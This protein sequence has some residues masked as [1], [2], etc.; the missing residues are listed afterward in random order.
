MNE[1][2]KKYL[3]I[4]ENSRFKSEFDEFYYSHPNY[5]SLFAVTDSLEALG[6]DNIAVNFPKERFL[7]L[8][9]TF[10]ANFQEGFVLVRKSNSDVRI[11]KENGEKLTMSNPSF[12][13]GWNGIILIIESKDIYDDTKR[14]FTSIYG[15]FVIL[16]LFLVASF[17]YFG[18]S[19][20]QVLG[21][22]VSLT[23]ISVSVLI[24]QEKF[25]VPN[26]VISKFCNGQDSSCNSVITSRERKITKN[27]SFS[28]VPFIFFSSCLLSL[29][30]DPKHSVVLIA[31]LSLSSIPVVIYSIWLQKAILR[32]W[33]PL[34]LIISLLMII[35]GLSLFGLEIIS[36]TEVLRDGYYYYFS[37]GAV[38][39]I[40]I[41]VSPQINSKIKSSERLNDLLRFKRDPNIFKILAKEIFS[42]EGMENLNG[43]HIGRDSCNL[44][45]KLFLSP[46]C[47]YCHSSYIDACNLVKKFPDKVNLTVFF[48][49]NPEN[50]SNPYLKIVQNLVAIQCE[51]GGQALEA[52]NDW[53]IEKMEIEDWLQKW[54]RDEI[55]ETVSHEIQKQY[56]WCL[57]NEFNYTPVKLFNT[58]I[59]P[60][61]YELI[62]LSYFVNEF[63]SADKELMTV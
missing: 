27:V 15:L 14:N 13:E 1:I 22:L 51:G 43:V 37:F 11:E 52:L 50:K 57:K 25:G 35:Q 38:L 58:F 12:V 63:E 59:L 60:K 4:N 62:E 2:V 10:L 23:G 34:C 41:F 26:M 6:I 53:H 21:V 3:T 29:L 45:I 42:F 36:L 19:L 18:I 28:D 56:D 39:S 48:N 5:P 20:Y 8:P 30:L 33:C 49:I 7:D 32:K 54:G 47:G 9:K 46:S 44:N 55:S 17:L 40:W 31:L 61:Q 24:L 16:L